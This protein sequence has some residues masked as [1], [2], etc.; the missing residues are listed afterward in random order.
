MWGGMGRSR[1]RGRNDPNNVCT[2]KYMNKEKKEIVFA[3]NYM[4]EH[5]K[6]DDS[7]IWAW[8]PV[9]LWKTLFETKEKLRV[10]KIT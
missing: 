4:K 10:P 7:V 1:G 9:F 5:W 3:G 2:Y 6:S 8:I